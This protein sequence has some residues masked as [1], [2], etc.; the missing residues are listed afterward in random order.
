MS[1]N[2]SGQNIVQV[3]L[4]VF[5]SLVT[6]ISPD[7][8]P[9]GVSPDQWD[10]QFE[11]GQAFSRN[12]FKKVFVTAF[13][14]N[15]TVTYGKSYVTP[16][17]DILNLYF[18]SNGAI[19]KEDFTNSPGTYTKL[20][21]ST[22]GMYA[23]SI[24]AFGR[25]YIAISDGLHGQDI[26]LQFDGTNL[27]RVTQDGPGAPPNISN[28][29]LPATQ[30]AV[31]G[32][33]GTV[34]IVEADPAGE[35]GGGYFT[36]L[37]LFVTS[38]GSAFVGQNIT[39]SGNSQGILNGTFSIIAIYPPAGGNGLIICSAY[40]PAGTTP[41]FGGT[42][43][44]GSGS[45]MVRSN[46]IVSVS[47][48]A[49]HQLQ[50]G[51]QTQ[52]TG[53][54]AAS[55]GGGVVS[56][57]INNED[58]PG[59][60]TVT[61][62]SAHGLVP[63][64]SVTI[65]GIVPA[66]SATITSAVRAG[67]ITTIGTSAP[68]NLSPGAV[69]AISGCDASFNTTTSVA[70]VISATVFN[71][72]QASAD[73]T[74]STLGIVTLY[75]PIPDTATPTYFEVESA[76]TATT[77]QIA[78]NYTDGTWGGG[79]VSYAWDGT[80]FVK[81]VSSSTTFQYQQYGPN[82]S[83]A[84][85]GFVSPY[86]QA[87]PGQHQMQ[88]LYLTRQ[89]Y[90]TAPSP[91]VTFVANGGQYLSVSNIPIG[92]SNVVAR[93]LAFT[94]A[95]G[96]YFFYIPVPAQVN[97]QQV[98]TATQINDNTTESVL[99]DFSDNTLFA[100]LGISI[101]GNNLANQIVL[102]GALGFGFYGT[103]L[104]TYGQRN[105][106]QNF[107]NMGFDGGALPSASAFPSGWNV[108]PPT[109]PSSAA[110][111]PGIHGTEGWGLFL[112]PGVA[113]GNLYQSAFRD[114][115]G[116]PI[117]QPNQTYIFRCWAQV[118]VI[119]AD[120]AIFI[121][122][123][124]TSLSFN[125]EVTLSGT[126]LSTTGSWVQGTFSLPTPAAIPSDLLL[127]VAAG[128]TTVTVRLVIDELSLI[129]ADNPYRT[130]LYG[131]YVNNPEGM[132]GVTGYFGPAQDTR[133]VMDMGIIRNSLY[134]LTR[135]PSGRL[136]QTSDNGTTEPV[137]WTVNQV[138]AN[139][140]A[141]SAFSLCKS[142][143]DDETGSGGEEWLSWASS[144]GARIFGG[145][146][147]WKIS[148]EIQPNWT[149]ASDGNNRGFLGLNF[150]AAT[151]I[152]SINDTVARII[153]FGVP[154]LD[155]AG[156]ATAPNVILTVNYRGLDNAYEIA[157][158]PPVR[159]SNQ[160]RLIAADNARKWSPWKRPMN[161]AAQMYRG[162]ALSTVF[163]AGNGAA[164]GASAGFGNVYTLSATKLTDDDY[165][166]IVPYYVTYPFVTTE[167]EQAYQLGSA[168]KMLS[169]ATAFIEGTGVMTVTY[170]VDILGNVWPLNSVRTMSPTQDYDMNFAGGSVT[171]EKIFF[172]YAS[173]PLPGQTDNGFSI[174]RMMAAMV[175]NA[176]LPVRGA[177]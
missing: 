120:M 23:K 139:C 114:A 99:L 3:P 162:P 150:A 128:S 146:E 113:A 112:S 51:F 102:D 72:P 59:L 71:F 144:T 158:S 74:S 22:P 157:K 62:A 47:T 156:P 94:G 26:P 174:S 137:G 90:T 46:N 161:G 81:S 118:D 142:Q 101:P 135:D 68:H 149:G 66:F 132:D 78:I 63:Q 173:A 83:T 42:G 16:T 19:W 119:A 69:I 138:A 170:M 124:S 127:I 73:A 32:V 28:V 121:E 60:A 159:T 10:M 75:W 56:I 34:S 49:P 84:S 152:W 108:T 93:I 168:R 33:P 160:G 109:S 14:G 167:Q 130:G 111:T 7:S 123:Q 5:G 117:I 172:K 2:V 175:K 154:S 35:V 126:A 147:P 27:D 141:L 25:E 36:A 57:V 129:Y 131:S 104:L 91:P 15:P 80:F 65:T 20:A 29:V 125:S 31:T 44:L 145:D 21:Q 37:N 4:G 136:H 100:G 12:G 106:V 164:P 166:L 143:A 88:V 82:A 86:G 13:P 64:L 153:Y 133:T 1:F 30:M 155:V 11:P 6:E 70:Q 148:Q 79:I 95:Q 103:R 176:K 45:T 110:L 55:V 140:G 89:G 40:F 177:A 107:L 97:G 54:P 17:G 53:V 24:T 134:L 105:T 48:A 165:G 116:A 39:V 52:I 92:P 98:S 76:P 87:A 122:L 38:T 41:G 171:G 61:T 169:Y 77:F 96:A 8:L 9:D 43:T 115:Y 50:T 151:T 18:D 58:S 85:V 163:F 67:E